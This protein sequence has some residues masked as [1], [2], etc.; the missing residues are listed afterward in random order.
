MLKVLSSKQCER[1]YLEPLCRE[2]EGL[3]TP[4][5]ACDVDNREG[6]A[7]RFEV[8]AT[9]RVS[10]ESKVSV[11][12]ASAWPGTN[13]PWLQETGAS[14]AEHLVVLDLFSA[15]IFVLCAI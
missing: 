2:L 15:C 9:F 11:E 14:N 4:G 8:V 5:C 10:V 7:L 12:P 6:L 3:A 13:E 1:G